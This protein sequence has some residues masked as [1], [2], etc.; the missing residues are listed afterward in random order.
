MNKQLTEEQIADLFLFC[1][2]NGVRYYEVQ[3]ELVDHLASAIEQ[4]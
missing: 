3:I 4:H 1:E 2:E